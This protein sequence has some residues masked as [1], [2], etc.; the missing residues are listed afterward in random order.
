ME[1]SDI[2]IEILKDI[3][4]E[5]REMKGGISSIEGDIS[6]MKGEL[7]E[8]GQGGNGARCD[9]TSALAVPPVVAGDLCSLGQHRDP[10]QTEL[11]GEP[12]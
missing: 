8:H 11:V 12:R 4:S 1:T 10:R 2:T 9:E 5:L 6:S 3:R 7:R